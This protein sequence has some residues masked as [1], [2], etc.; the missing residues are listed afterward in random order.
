MKEHNDGTKRQRKCGFNL[1]F[2]QTLLN[3]M[4]QKIVKYDRDD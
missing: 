4:I 1:F 2:K 3:K